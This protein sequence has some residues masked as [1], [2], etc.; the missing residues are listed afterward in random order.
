VL[1]SSRLRGT[2]LFHLMAGERINTTDKFP[3]LETIGVSPPATDM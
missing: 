1:Q 2:N 3:D